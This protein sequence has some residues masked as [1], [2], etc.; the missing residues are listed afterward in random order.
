MATIEI[1]LSQFQNRKKTI[2]ILIDVENTSIAQRWLMALDEVLRLNLFLKK[3]F[4]F[5]GFQDAPEDVAF[6]LRKL[7]RFVGEINSFRTPGVWAKGYH[8]PCDYSPRDLFRNG[9]YHPEPMW[10]VHHHF[11]LLIGQR[12]AYSPYYAEATGWIKYCITQINDI[13]HQ[14]E[15]IC[16]HKELALKNPA[17]V[18]PY[19]MFSY[20][21]PMFPFSASDRKHFKID[22]AKFGGV[23]IKYAQPGKNHWE[24]F[25][26]RDTEIFRSN[27]S[28]LQAYTGQFII[29]WGHGMSKK[30]LAAKKREFYA[31]LRK[32]GW[33]PKDRSLSLGR[34]KVGQVRKSTFKGMTIPEVHQLLAKHNNV[35]KITI[36]SK[37]A[38]TSQT[39]PLHLR[40][41][42]YDR[43]QAFKSMLDYMRACTLSTERG[44]LWTE[45]ESKKMPAKEMLIY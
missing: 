12:W 17:A 10:G 24:T 9:K 30:D 23:Y 13:L 4:C 5:M 42:D 36:S 11:E 3:D 18:N 38:K 31:W 41:R 33:D 32:N 43:A 2:P 25:I 37:A 15:W 44:V 26:E 28:G 45:R 39:Y 34:I 19:T 6:W 20:T 16:R 27:V 35:E 8:I 7:K 1:I 14:I 29:E 21:A 22:E 40:D